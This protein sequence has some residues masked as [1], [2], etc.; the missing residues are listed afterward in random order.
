VKKTKDI[1]ER[2]WNGYQKNQKE[3]LSWEV[4]LVDAMTVSTLFAM[5]ELYDIRLWPEEI[6]NTI[7]AAN[8]L[9]EYLDGLRGKN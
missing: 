4:M 2:L 6:Q 7:K 9:F 3:H 8:D 5:S 1:I